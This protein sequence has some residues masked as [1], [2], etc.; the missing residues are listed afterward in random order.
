MS[1]KRKTPA[2][3]DPWSVDID[4]FGGIE[5]ERIKVGKKEADPRE[6][7]VV[8]M[9]GEPHASVSS[10]QDYDFATIEYPKGD[11]RRRF[12]DAYRKNLKDVS[13]RLY[14]VRF[15][16][17]SESSEILNVY[18]YLYEDDPTVSYRI[19]DTS[20]ILITTFYET[21]EQAPLPSSPLYRQF[22]VKNIRTVM[23]ETLLH[24]SEDRLET[25]LHASFPE[26]VRVCAM[27]SVY[28]FVRGDAFESLC[29]DPARLYALRGFVY[30]LLKQEDVDRV[31]RREDFHIR[32]DNVDTYIHTGGHHY[33]NSDYMYSCPEI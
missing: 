10:S 9:P 28:L 14:N 22:F 3:Q 23:R 4:Q 5:P 1:A 33:F 8:W 24:Q 30:D 16:S 11:L 17:P 7:F 32:V 29:A 19:E 12:A 21:L 6:T 26:I 18:I 31:L 2:P 13:I 27:N 15:D 25:A 20:H